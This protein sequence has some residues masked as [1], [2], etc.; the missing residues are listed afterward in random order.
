M[1][2]NNVIGWWHWF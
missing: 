2:R 1:E